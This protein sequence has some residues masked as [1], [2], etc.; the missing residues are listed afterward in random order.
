MNQW[1]DFVEGWL[2]GVG[3]DGEDEVVS[4]CQREKGRK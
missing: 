3:A 2:A 4:L 1:P